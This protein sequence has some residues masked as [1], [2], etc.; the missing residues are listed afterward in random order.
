M[1]SKWSYIV[2][3]VLLAGCGD[4]DRGREASSVAVGETIYQRY[5]FACHGSGAG[6]AP[7]RGDLEAWQARI[8]KGSDALLAST[9]TGLPPGMPPRGMCM[10][11]SDAELAAAVG[12]MI[13]ASG[14]N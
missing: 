7:R 3:S 4:A 1:H 6:G 8:G 5:C 12:Y 11:C 9:I 13:E 2:A 14:A 10:E